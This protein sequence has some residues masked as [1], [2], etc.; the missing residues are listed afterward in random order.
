MSALMLNL[1]I[2]VSAGALFVVAVLVL[3]Y[4]ATR[5]FKNERLSSYIRKSQRGYRDLKASKN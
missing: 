1:S 3:D 5:V 4:L 2:S